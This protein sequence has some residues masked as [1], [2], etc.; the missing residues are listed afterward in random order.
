[1][2]SGNVGSGVQIDGSGTTQNVVAGNFIG[3]NSV[4]NAAVGNGDIGVKIASGAQSNVIGTN[5]DRTG[6]SV[7]GNVISGNA[8]IGVDITDLGT[9]YNVLAGNLIGTDK[10]GTIAVPNATPT[11]GSGGALIDNLAAFNRIG[12]NGDGVSDDLERNV[13]SGNQR[14]MG[15][16]IQNATDNVVAGNYIGTASD[17]TTP[18]PNAGNGMDIKAG[19]QRNRIGT[20]ADG[21]GD[22]AERNVISGNGGTGIIIW[23]P[24]TAHNLVAGNYIGTDKTGSVAL[25]NTGHGIDIFNGAQSNTIG[26]TSAASRNV[27]L[28]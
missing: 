19:S 17:G 16:M 18:L 9:N 8:N 6:D 15:L 5:G 4:G 10:T 2:I 12:T 3:T 14:F 28:E 13:I 24:G 23:Q 21:V 26:G 20:N 1:M 7:E 27:D 25:G 11:T 22:A